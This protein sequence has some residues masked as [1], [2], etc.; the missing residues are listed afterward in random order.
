MLHKIH[1]GFFIFAKT[2]ILLCLPEK[3]K[4]GMNEII[5]GTLKKAR[6]IIIGVIGLTVLIIGI[7]LLVLP[8]PAVI[9]IPVG[10]GIL[11]TE[12]AWARHLLK[13]VRDKIK[14]NTSSSFSKK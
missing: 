4:K 8:G 3:D 11:A 6:R 2:K 7:A 9:V 12:F 10:L 14:E 13:K 5:Y 1:L